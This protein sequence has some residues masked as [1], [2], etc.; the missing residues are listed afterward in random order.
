M[1]R[2][3]REKIKGRAGK[4]VLAVIIVPFVFFGAES[5]LTGGGGAAAVLSING[6]KIDEQ[7]VA[8]ERMIVRNELLSRMGNDVDFEQLEDERLT[9]LAI[10][11]LTQSTLLKQLAD[12]Q[13]MSV[14]QNMV[15]KFIVGMPVFQVD[16]K[17]SSQQ[18]EM[19][20][21]ESGMDLNY[22][23][24]RLAEDVRAA[25]IRNG[26]AL[27]S[28]VVS[29]EVDLLFNIASESRTVRWA[30]LP[31]QAVKNSLDISDQAMNAYYQANLSEYQAP[32]LVDAEYIVLDMS[33]F[34]QPI[35][36]VMLQKEYDRQFQQFATTERRKI[37]HILLESDGGQSEA[38]LHNKMTEIQQK[39][40][41]GESFASLAKAYSQDSGSASDGGDLG[42]T[43]RDGTFPEAFE[44]AAFALAPD[45]IS[46]VIET[47]AG[48][49]LI[50]VT[51]I[52]QSEFAPLSE[53]RETLQS[54]LQLR[55]AKKHYVLAV[56]QLADLAFNA[57]DLSDP[58]AEMDLQVNLQKG[59]SREGLLEQSEADYWADSRILN[60]LFSD[61]VLNGELNTEVIEIDAQKSIVLRVKQLIEPRQK[62]F[63][64]VKSL[65]GEQLRA[66][67][68]EQKLEEIAG[69]LKELVENGESLDAVLEQRGYDT[70]STITLT[71]QSAE[72]EPQMIEAVF[73]APR[74]QASAAVYTVASGLDSYVFQLL[75]VSQV[76][77]A[78]K[79]ASADM[80]EQQ[81]NA[82]SV[83]QQ[84]AAYIEAIKQ[85][86]IIERY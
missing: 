47:D 55:E 29:A 66:E 79:A 36:E 21:A 54:Q 40:A 22:M 80:F 18:L 24:S 45:A 76:D 25:Q 59:V 56:E 17:F 33:N 31:Y 11:R 43:L 64:E 44:T 50:T 20:L 62:G 41:A 39:Y 7:R 4:V 15:E 81:T 5:L 63:D 82:L 30:K 28:F 60:A 71:R 72:L 34:Y 42:Y 38:Q 58:A 49:H 9:P 65:V 3:F 48:L 2:T 86:A 10:N 75:E 26:V 73:S 46:E 8:Q 74:Q 61:E 51:D 84:T 32:M 1:L 13:K 37:S 53:M 70:A 78:Q 83:Q 35:S 57:P 6:E 14:P 68:T 12:Q 85:T 67:K 52:E 27:S 69:Q 77:Q 19:V 23:K 16:G